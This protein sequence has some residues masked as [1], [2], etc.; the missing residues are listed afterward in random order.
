MDISY[1]VPRRSHLLRGLRV[2]PR[3]FCCDP[4]TLFAIPRFSSIAEEDEKKDNGLY[5]AD[6]IQDREHPYVGKLALFNCET[7]SASW[8]SGNTAA[9]DQSILPKLL[10]LGDA[11]YFQ[12]SG[13]QDLY[14]LGSGHSQTLITQRFENAAVFLPREAT[15][16]DYLRVF[17][18]LGEHSRQAASMG[19]TA[20]NGG[21][22]QSLYMPVLDRMLEALSA[23]GSVSERILAI[24]TTEEIGTFI[25]TCALTTLEQLLKQIVKNFFGLNGW[26]IYRMDGELTNLINERDMIQ[27]MDYLRRHPEGILRRVGTCPFKLS[28][29]T[30]EQ[31]FRLVAAL[32]DAINSSQVNG[33]HLAAE[34]TVVRREFTVLLEHVGEFVSS[35]GQYLSH[36]PRTTTYGTLPMQDE[37]FDCLSSLLYTQVGDSCAS[38][39]ACLRSISRFA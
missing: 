9:T 21:S 14:R 11:R 37:S 5:D 22:D 38:G 30:Y 1:G 39:R 20:S 7:K 33:R 23:V 3:I 36:S 35:F 8:M 18:C 16:R 24:C 19:T 15:V 32:Q 12:H 13:P 10:P 27:L 6:V 4:P 26:V 34:Q 31:L 25:C 28:A 29:S 17:A 2:Q